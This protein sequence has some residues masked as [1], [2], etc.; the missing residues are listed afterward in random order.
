MESVP[1]WWESNKQNKLI[2]IADIYEEHII[3][4]TDL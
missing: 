3:K 4:R 1:D 2:W